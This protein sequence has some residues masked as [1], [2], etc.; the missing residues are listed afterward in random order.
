MAFPDSYKGSGYV[1]HQLF[2]FVRQRNGFLGAACQH[3]RD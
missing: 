1:Q 2:V 3:R